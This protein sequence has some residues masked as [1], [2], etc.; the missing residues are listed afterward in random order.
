MEISYLDTISLYDRLLNKAI[1]IV[2]N[3]PYYAYPTNNEFLK[4]RLEGDN[5]VL[6]WPEVQSG[7][8]NSCDIREQ[9]AAFPAKLL[10]MSDEELLEWQTEEA[11]KQKK[12]E[13]AR[14]RNQKRLQKQRELAELK[15]LKA[16][17]ESK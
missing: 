1:S 6:S 15:R 11:N 8:Y 4:I 5:I 13:Q 7:Y 14:Q 10:L 2:R 9:K 12:K 17:Y 3:S 16:K